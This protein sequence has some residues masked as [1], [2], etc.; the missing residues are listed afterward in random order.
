MAYIL[1]E[2]RTAAHPS[3]WHHQNLWLPRGLR[4]F[5]RRIAVGLHHHKK[6]RLPGKSGNPNP[7]IHRAILQSPN[8]A[9]GLYTRQ[10]RGTD[11][12][13]KR[14][15][16]RCDCFAQFRAGPLPVSSGDNDI[17]SGIYWTVENPA[18]SGHQVN[19]SKPRL[20]FQ[21]VE[22]RASHHPRRLP[23]QIGKQRQQPKG[24]MDI[25][26]NARNCKALAQLGN[27]RI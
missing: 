1:A 3:K 24:R 12:E 4:L 22:T 16:R 18:K 26:R 20:V 11:C 14:F 2:Q 6:R 25:G 8:P 5:L 7:K 15:K 19:D 23:H 17:K 13:K 27:H 21:L 10:R 9:I